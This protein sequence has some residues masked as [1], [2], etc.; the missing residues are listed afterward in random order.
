MPIKTI[1]VDITNAP[2]I[3]TEEINKTISILQEGNLILYPT[4]TGWV[5]GCDATNE[6]AVKKV[7]LLKNIRSGNYIECLVANDA[8]LEKYVEN[9]PDLAYDLMD[10]ATKPMIILYDNPKYVAKQLLD[11]DG[12]FAVRVA[13]DKFC[14]YLINKFKKPLV[15]TSANLAGSASPKSF[16]D[17]PQAILKGVA[18]VVNLQKESFRNTQPSVIKLGTYGKVTI[19]KK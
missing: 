13:E 5:I 11:K 16:E 9:V 2:Y 7:T 8:M 15:S 14:Q 18:Y 10:L 6:A 12:S 17:I 4:D 3:L 19:I 1:F